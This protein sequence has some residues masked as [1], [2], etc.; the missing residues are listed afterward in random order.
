MCMYHCP[1]AQTPPWEVKKTTWDVA[2]TAVFVFTPLTNCI[3][4]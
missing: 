2:Y 1:R 3:G 4:A